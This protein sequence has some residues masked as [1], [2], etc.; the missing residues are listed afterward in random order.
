MILLIFSFLFLS[1]SLY[2]FVERMSDA[3]GMR[4]EKKKRNAFLLFPLPYCCLG[5]YRDIQNCSLC[6][7]IVYLQ[8]DNRRAIEKK[9][10]LNSPIIL[11]PTAHTVVIVNGYV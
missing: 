7:Y 1:L 10:Y 4:T 3:G 11:F 9:S 6:L 8:K 2:I 5:L